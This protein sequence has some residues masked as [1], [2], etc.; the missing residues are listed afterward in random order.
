MNVIL[1]GKGGNWHKAQTHS[2]YSVYSNWLGTSNMDRWTVRTKKIIGR[3]GPEE[4]AFNA[5]AW[6]QQRQLIWTCYAQSDFL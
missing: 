2:A 4:R 6:V 3:K 1:E 5:A